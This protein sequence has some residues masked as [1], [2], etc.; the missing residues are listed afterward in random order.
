[1]LTGSIFWFTI[2]TPLFSE[3]RVLTKKAPFVSAVVA[4]TVASEI[5]V[6]FCLSAKTESAVGFV[7]PDAGSTVANPPVS[8]APLP[9]VVPLKPPAAGTVNGTTEVFAAAPHGF[10][11]DCMSCG[12]GLASTHA[13]AAASTQPPALLVMARLSC[14]GFVR[15]P[16]GLLPQLTKSETTGNEFVVLQGTS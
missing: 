8:A 1:M 12:I 2:A 16:Q 5:S 10:V 3:P 15:L 6:P 9:L 11:I 14:H 13:G 7:L 4:G